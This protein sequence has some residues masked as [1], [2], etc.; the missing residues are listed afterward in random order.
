MIKSIKN[1]KSKYFLLLPD[2]SQKRMGL[3]KKKKNVSHFLIT[4]KTVNQC[5][6]TAYNVLVMKKRETKQ[7]QTNKEK[8]KKK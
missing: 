7:Q 4:I 2:L 8:S 3:L 1:A 5:F 6:L